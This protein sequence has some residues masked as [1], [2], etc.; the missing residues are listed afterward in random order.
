MYCVGV[1]TE[2]RSFSKKTLRCYKSSLLLT[3]GTGCVNYVPYNL[4]NYSDM[5]WLQSMK[6]LCIT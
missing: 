1:I 6:L 2:N 3:V 5:A 4:G